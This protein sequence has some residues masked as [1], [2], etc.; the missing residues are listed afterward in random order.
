MS[1]PQPRSL[2]DESECQWSGRSPRRGNSVHHTARCSRS[3]AH[4]S[5][6]RSPRAVAAPRPAPFRLGPIALAAAVVV[7]ALAPRPV[8]GGEGLYLTWDDCALGPTATSN[9]AFACNTNDGA[10]ELYVAFTMPQ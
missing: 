4:A 3:P 1:L 8:R 5:G 2:S 6:R 10:N 9:L 7:L